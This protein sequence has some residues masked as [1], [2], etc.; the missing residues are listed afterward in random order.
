MS[1]VTFEKIARKKGQILSVVSVTTGQ[2]VSFPAFIDNFSD[3][4]NVSWGN[5]ESFGRVDPVKQYRGTSRRISLT[6]SVL[7]PDR[8]KAEE[9]LTQ[10][11]KFIQMLYPVY[12]EP[13][14]TRG[15]AARTI[16]APPIL[17]VKLMNYIQSANGSDGLIGCISGLTFDPDF[18][19]SHFIR[20]DGTIVPQIFRISFNFVPQHDSEIGFNSSGDF[21]TQEFPYGQTQTPIASDATES[22]SPNGRADVANVMS[23]GII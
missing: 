11:S 15:S 23:I 9:N 19:S 3:N 13:L 22:S 1:I 4:Y 10:Y 20:E 16:K 18:K 2:S 17:K 12:S 6:L 7:A 5:E 21:L 8:A 14:N